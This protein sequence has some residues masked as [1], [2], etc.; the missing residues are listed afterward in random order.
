MATL[1]LEGPGTLTIEPPYLLRK[2]DVSEEE[3]ERLAEIDDETKVEWFDGVLIMHSP[4]IPRHDDIGTFLSSLLR[5]FVDARS[6]GRLFGAAS[7]KTHLATCRRFAPDLMFIEQSKTHL[8]TE[9]EVDCAPDFVVE[10]LS[11]STRDY[12][13][14]EKRLAYREAT[15]R[16]IW[17][18]DF[19]Q[20]RLIVDRRQPDGTY[21][22]EVL[23]SGRVLSS[24]VTGFWIETS[25]LWTD[26]LPN[27]FQCLQEILGDLP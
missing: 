11:E 27:A 2:Y 17:F 22:D 7:V 9:K 5:V 19:E 20:Q 14:E 3:F 6:L 10:I 23:T 1:V 16:E 15:V 4:T 21:R 13:L 18:V 25:W 26:P 24:E 8:V 12:D